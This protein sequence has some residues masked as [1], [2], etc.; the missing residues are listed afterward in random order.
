MPLF[1][2]PGSQA[3]IAIGEAT[4]GRYLARTNCAQCHGTSLRGDSNPDFT[5]PS[6]QVVAAYS[7]G[8]FTQLLRAGV[9]PGER[10][11]P[12]MGPTARQNL[13]HHTEAEIAA[14]YSYLHTLPAAAAK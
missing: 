9:A 3:R 7:P 4:F 8:A 14:L 1:R 6:L 2:W 11:L 13:S 12:V 10:N 5:S